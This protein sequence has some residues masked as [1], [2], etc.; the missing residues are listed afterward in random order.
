MVLRLAH[1]GAHRGRPFARGIRRP[2]SERSQG[3]EK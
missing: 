3:L 1:Y 2:K